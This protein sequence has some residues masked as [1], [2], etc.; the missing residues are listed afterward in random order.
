MTD[1]AENKN[2]WKL[3]SLRWGVFR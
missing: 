3:L 2:R 1:A